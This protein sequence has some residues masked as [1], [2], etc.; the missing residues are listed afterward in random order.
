M[1]KI[2]NSFKFSKPAILKVT[3]FNEFNST[4]LSILMIAFYSLYDFLKAQFSAFMP[5]SSSAVSHE[6]LDGEKPSG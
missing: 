4:Q 1:L 3:M 2:A 5:P 6:S